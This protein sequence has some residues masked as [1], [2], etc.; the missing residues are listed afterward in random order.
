MVA[1]FKDPGGAEPNASDPGPIGNHY[2]TLIN[3]GDGTTSLGTITPTGGNN[4]AV[5]ASHIY[6]EE[7]TY[8]ITV[9]IAHETSSAQVVTDTA[10]VSNPAVVAVGG[11]TFAGVEGTS[12]TGKVATFTDP[13]GPEATSEGG[14]RYPGARSRSVMLPV[15]GLASGHK[16]AGDR[17]SARR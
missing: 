6:T 15:G 5:T 10:S 13:G 8:T 11:F 7:G 16:D 9:T 14:G 4:F 17:G 1:T 2:T 3:W 12:V